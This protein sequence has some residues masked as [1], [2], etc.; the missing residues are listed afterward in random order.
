MVVITM[1]VLDLAAHQGPFRILRAGPL[2][3]PLK[4]DPQGLAFVSVSI[5]DRG[6]CTTEVRG[7]NVK[8]AP[9]G[10]ISP[11]ARRLQVVS[12]CTSELCMLLPGVVHAFSSGSLQPSALHIQTGFA[13]QC[14]ALVL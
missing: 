12:F 14:R 9:H 10:R 3:E 4:S 11:A 6:P 7:N 5:T 13:C 2:R 8:F 1:A